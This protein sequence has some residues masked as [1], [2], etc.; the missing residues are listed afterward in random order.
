MVQGC[1]MITDRATFFLKNL[2]FLGGIMLSYNFTRSGQ[3]SSME[4]H[5]LAIIDSFSGESHLKIDQYAKMLQRSPRTVRRLIK[6]LRDRGFI[7]CRYGV[8]KSLHLALNEASEI[9]HKLNTRIKKTFSYR[10]RP[11]IKT[12][13][14]VP[15]NIES[16]KE[17]N[18]A[19]KY[20]V[21]RKEY[22][23]SDHPGGE[24]PPIPA[25]LQGIWNRLLGKT[26]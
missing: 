9:V 21:V 4:F 17:K 26:L 16:N 1:S 3:V 15:F 5:L 18:K 25:E 11:T 20:A 24:T 2:N 19:A 13:N 8:W 12:A 7:H 14:K 23:D 10:P 6:S 22:G